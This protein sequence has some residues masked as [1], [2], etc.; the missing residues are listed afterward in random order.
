MS[1][2]YPK[3][4]DSLC[5][6]FHNCSSLPDI[7]ALSE[8]RLSCN[9][10]VPTLDN[11]NFECINSSSAAG[12]VG[13]YISERLTYS[14]RND[15]SLNLNHCEDLWLNVTLND[16]DPSLSKRCIVVGI[17][18]R[19]PGH[20]YE[21]FTKKLCMTLNRLNESKTDYYLTGDFNIDLLKYNL[22]SN[23]TRYMNSLNSV[24]CN[25]CIDK[26]TRITYGQSATCID[27][28][29][30]SLSPDLINSSILYSDASDH[31]ST[32]S[33]ISDVRNEHEDSDIYIRK[34]NLTPEQWVLFN[35][36]LSDIL[37]SKIP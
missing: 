1:E 27:H 9:K 35:N 6:I 28:I 8:T 20:N 29:Y 32:V 12:G 22:A 18:Y 2:A 24:G 36:R 4:F 37:L 17:I 5:D 30:S 31:F 7:L 14:V 23:V 26:P 3:N 33:T 19:H 16:N 34:S 21:T 13:A 15:L 25:V 10:N 11:Y